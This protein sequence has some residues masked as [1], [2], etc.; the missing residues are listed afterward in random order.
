MNDMLVTIFLKALFPGIN[1][2]LVEFRTILEKDTFQLF[3]NQDFKKLEFIWPY[4]GTKNI[5]FGVATRKD[6][7]SGKKENCNYLSAIFIDIDCGTDGHKKASWF[8]TKDDALAHLE[9]LDLGQSIVVDSGH[10]LHIYWLLNKPL[11]LTAENIQKAENLM[12]KIASV[13]GGDTAYD[14]SRIL[15]MPGTSN[16][17]GTE[18]VD[19]KF[20]FSN[21]ERK[22]KFEDLIQKIQDHPAV[23]IPFDLLKKNKQGAQFFNSIFGI[24]NF[25][26]SDRSALDQKIICYLLKQ[27]FSEE[28][29]ISVFKYFSTSGK[30]LERYEND[31]AGAINYL[32]H[33]IQNAQ[34]FISNKGSDIIPSE[35]PSV[36]NTNDL[37]LVEE[38]MVQE[39]DEFYLVKDPNSLGYYIKGDKRLPNRMTNFI[40]EIIK[41]IKYPD[42]KSSQTVYSGRIILADDSEAFEYLP[43]DTICNA[44]ELEKFIGNACG[45]KAKFLK[46][47]S[48]LPVAIRDFNNNIECIK[49]CDLGYNNDFTKYNTTNMV[50]SADKIIEQENIILHREEFQTVQPSFG[51]CEKNEIPSYYNSYIEKMI[52]SENAFPNLVAFFFSFIPLIYPFLKNKASNKPFLMLFGPSGCGKSTT[53]KLMLEMYGST[54][55]LFN[56]SSTMTG[57]TITGNALKDILFGIDDLKI[58][59][60]SN[61]QD[62]NKFMT[63]LQNY[64]DG[65]SRSRS[66]VDLTLKKDRPIQSTLMICAEDNILSEAST[67]ARG[68]IV[69]MKNI[70][71][72]RSILGELTGLSK[73]MNAAIPHFIQ[74]L[75]NKRDCLL[76]SFNQSQIE[77]DEIIRNKNLTGDNRERMI[78]NFALLKTSFEVVSG[79]FSTEENNDYNSSLKDFFNKNFAELFEKNLHRVQ[80]NKVDEVFE[81]TFWALIENNRIWLENF[82]SRNSFSRKVGEYRIYNDSVKIVLNLKNA[83]DE[84][85]RYLSA[86]S[87]GLGSIENLK[88]LLIQNN[89]IRNTP[90]G[91]I[92]FS[93][94]YSVRGVEWIGDYPKSY[95]GLREEQE[96]GE[97]IEMNTNSA[98]TDVDNFA[99]SPQNEVFNFFDDDNYNPKD[100]PF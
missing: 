53:V 90:S 91:K 40:V 46:S 59:N 94:N 14:V 27:G 79:F 77:I 67:I 1:K 21:F 96:A 11:E 39:S 75:L 99:S 98:N 26:T 92:S 32:N 28:N 15:R 83:H 76:E 9:R 81:S 64:G 95:F 6:A 69:E 63:M 82:N 19:C 85:D 84:V 97:L 48:L 31:P 49:A 86:T 51:K 4:N 74:H 57:L 24:E 13:C 23:S 68:I 25:D 16:I 35:S 44:K 34:G 61:P 42:E 60:F 56:C 20:I 29:L 65:S 37:F 54:N 3:V 93:E 12:K 50:I 41:Q 45:I 78:N 43:N 36:E 70:V 87:S 5:Y 55:S 89:K 8:K 7:S 30:F 47:T 18:K 33:S 2:G 17:K 58:Q 62:K 66:S 80:E 52:S 71:S 88:K 10:G 72:D 73:K 100:L 22:Y 38:N